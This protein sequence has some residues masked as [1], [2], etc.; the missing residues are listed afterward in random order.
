MIRNGGNLDIPFVCENTDIYIPVDIEGAG[1][2]LGDIHA[3]QGYGELSGIAMEASSKII[4]DVEV[5]RTKYRLDNILVVGKEP[6][7]KKAT[8]LLIIYSLP[9]WQTTHQ[10]IF[11]VFYIIFQFLKL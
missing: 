10:K 3:I 11:L 7:S 8:L 9:I 6:F 5:L 4:L 1:L 2:Y